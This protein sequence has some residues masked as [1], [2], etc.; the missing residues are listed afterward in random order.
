MPN[1]NGDQTKTTKIIEGEH[2]DI[3]AT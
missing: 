3:N 1:A 2:N